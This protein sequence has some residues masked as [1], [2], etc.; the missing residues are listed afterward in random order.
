MEKRAH[1]GHELIPQEALE[2]SAGFQKAVAQRHRGLPAEQLIG[3][4]DVRPPLSRIVDRQRQM[5]DAR[6][7]AGELDHLLGEFADGELAR[8]A[9]IDGSG[10]L[11]GCT[12]ETHET[13][14]EIVHIAEGPRMATVSIDGDV[15]V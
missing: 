12:H 2:I 14:D 5:Y 10:D 9:E 13:V 3:F 1:R 8:V 7:G 6:E 11:V 4:A 15:P